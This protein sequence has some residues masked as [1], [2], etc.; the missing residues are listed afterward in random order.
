V[1]V[2]RHLSDRLTVKYSM[3]T[4]EGERLERAVADYRLYPNVTASGYRDS[5]GRFGGA[6][7]WRLEF[8]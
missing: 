1:T 8:R 3:G 5:L 4:E 2:G 7:R 6:L